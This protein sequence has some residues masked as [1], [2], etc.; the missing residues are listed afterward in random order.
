MEIAKI[1]F[2]IMFRRLA[3]VVICVITVVLCF[4]ELYSRGLFAANPL[5][6]TP[7]ATVTVKN[8]LAGPKTWQSLGW[9][10][11]S[12]PTQQTL[13]DVTAKLPAPILKLAGQA[14]PSGALSASHSSAIA[15]SSTATQSG[16]STASAQASDSA[17]FVM[18]DQWQKLQHELSQIW[19]RTQTAAGALQIFIRTQLF[20]PTQTAQNSSASATPAP[21][22]QRAIEYA[23]YMYCKETVINYEKQYPE[24]LS[25]ALPTTPTP[26]K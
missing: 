15:T 16:T 23:K 21:L 22:E 4:N 2:Q 6:Q 9:F 5:K 24:V 10:N 1:F 20:A 14:S 8:L 3:L 25:G 13:S 17:D 12:L 26:I 11:W 7:I 18:S 19:G